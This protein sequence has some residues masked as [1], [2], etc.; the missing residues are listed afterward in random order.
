MIPKKEKHILNIHVPAGS[1][2]AYVSHIS[3]SPVEREFIIPRGSNLKYHH[4]ET[5]PAEHPI[6]GKY[7][8]QIHHM[9]LV[10]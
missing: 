7:N 10:K 9:T 4:T 8:K 5:V 1:H 3:A 2:G 6:D